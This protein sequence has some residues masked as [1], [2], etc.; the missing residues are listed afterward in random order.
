MHTYAWL[1]STSLLVHMGTNLSSVLPPLASAFWLWSSVLRGILTLP[2]AV[3]LSHSDL[4]LLVL[5]HSKLQHYFHI[6]TG[7]FS[8]HMRAH[9]PFWCLSS[10]A[11]MII[12]LPHL[13][14]PFTWSLSRFLMTRNCL[15]FLS[16]YNLYLY[17]ITSLCP[18][19]FIQ[20]KPMMH[21]KNNL[22]KNP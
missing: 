5:L 7:G 20:P 19:F 10:L 11:Q 12:S 8:L 1:N 16:N 2:R 21:H 3:G 9:L 18:L 4:I 15:S 14:C 13:R 6:M 22:L 17:H